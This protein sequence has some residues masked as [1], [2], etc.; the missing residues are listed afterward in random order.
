ME[1]GKLHI[2]CGDGKGKTTAAAGLAVR[3]AGSK[4]K[5]LFVQF[6]K[7]GTSSEIHVLEHIP[8]IRVLVCPES[9]GFTFRMTSSERNAAQEAYRALW[10]KAIDFAC[11]EH[12]DLLVLDEVLSAYHT[13]M[14]DQKKVLEFLGGRPADMEIVLTGREA[15]EEL[16]MLADYVTEMHK[17]RHPYEEEGL[18]AREGIEY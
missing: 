12:V 13:G 2:Y 7:D 15:G 1:N 6:L 18:T 9:F 14:V 4:R 16:I 5:V 11:S 10:K 3:C 8:G 17:I